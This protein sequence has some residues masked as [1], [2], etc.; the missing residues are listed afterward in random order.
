[1]SSTLTRF[2]GGGETGPVLIRNVLRFGCLRYT[3]LRHDGKSLSLSGVSLRMGCDKINSRGICAERP[4][5][6]RVIS[7]TVLDFY[8]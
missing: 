3:I 6:V 4:V 1:V 7:E 8:R 2:V 5:G